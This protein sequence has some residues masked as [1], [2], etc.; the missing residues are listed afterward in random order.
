MKIVLS[1]IAVFLFCAASFAQS[2][3]ISLS[4]YD[5]PFRVAGPQT[6]NT[7]PHIFKQN[8]T[9]IRNGKTF[10]TITEVRESES[11]EY[12]RI[13]STD[14]IDD[15]ETSRYQIKAGQGNVFCSED[16]VRWK[17]SKNE[18]SRAGIYLPGMLTESVDYSVT[19][20]SVDGK[21]VWVYRK[22][23]VL[24]A[25]EDGPKTF[26]ERTYTIDSRGYL[27]NIIDT[28]GTLDPRTVTLTREQT[29]ITGAM[30][31][32]IIAPIK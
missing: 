25:V 22:Y 30:I 17:P 1:I 9:F 26:E 10:R 20:K 32:P 6:I 27:L 15:R 29:W 13:K 24:P 16:G 23:S 18:C 2:Q 28:H 7:Y 31:E 11:A 5:K 19:E 14:I 21:K 8:I 3:T 4:E 12:E